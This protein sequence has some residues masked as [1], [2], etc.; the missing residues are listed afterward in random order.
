ML[1][2]PTTGLPLRGP[3]MSSHG[4]SLPGMAAAGSAVSTEA[5]FRAASAGGQEFAAWMAPHLSADGAVLRDRR[6]AADRVEDAH[7]NNSVAVA[8]T[9][10]LVDML[11]GAGLRFSSKPKAEALGVSRED[12][13]ALGAQI[14]REF[15]RHMSDPRKRIDAQRKLSGAGLM[16]LI[17]RSFVKLGEACLMATWRDGQGPYETCFQAI[18]PA[19]L[20][21]PSGR[22]S[23]ANLRD[24]VVLDSFGAPVA[25]H[26]RNS[27]SGEFGSMGQATWITIPRETEWGRPVFMHV[28]EPEREDQNR[29]M[30]P[31]A[32]TLG[33]MRMLDRWSDHEVAAAAVNALYAA[34]VKSNLPVGE[35]L[36]S[37]DPGA[38]GGIEARRADFYSQ[39]PLKVNGVR[40]PVLPA[41]DE[42]VM[43]GTPRQSAAFGDF[44]TAF[45]QQIAA[46]RGLSYEQ[47]AMDFT[48]STY[49]SVRAALN[50]TWRMVKRLLAQFVEQ[51]PVPMLL[52]IVEEGVDKG[53]IIAPQGCAPLWDDPAA[54]LSGRWIGPG[55]GYTDPVREAEASALRM[56][57]MIS[58]LESECAEQGYDWEETLDQIEREENEFARRGLNRATVASRIAARSAAAAPAATD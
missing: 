30:S 48:R 10:R 58:T 40:I 46:A 35:V 3:A 13:R 5:A 33:R 23:G 27:H 44:N 36:A 51:G 26:V 1:V 55:R 43:N 11:V 41:G 12:A 14:E 53:H 52:A 56:E 16:R 15:T 2:H 32:P 57:T 34:Y 50:E 18:D 28:F 42:L 17:A 22:L 8:A 54:W 39:A 49:S 38:M 37:M 6:V 19:R 25:Y 31:M 29:A 45:L 7:R 9:M 21:N 20:C 24:G 47:M 4:M